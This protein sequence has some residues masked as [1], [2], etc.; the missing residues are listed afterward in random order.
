MYVVYVVYV[1][2]VLYVMHIN[3][4]DVCN[5][6]NVIMYVMYVMYVM[7]VATYVF[8]CILVESKSDSSYENYHT[9]CPTK[10]ENK[11]CVGVT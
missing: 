3:A 2:Y 6:C 8:D 10:V 4:C 9:C 1:M 11:A 5:V 7:F